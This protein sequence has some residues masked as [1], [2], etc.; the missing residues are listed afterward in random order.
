MKNNKTLILLVLAG[1]GIWYYMKKK[2]TKTTE[3]LPGG[4]GGPGGGPADYV[5][6]DRISPDLSLYTPPNAAND[7]NFTF[8]IN[9]IK[10]RLGN[11]P[12]TI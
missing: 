10:K 6:Q 8:S 1:L 4:K 5:R 7:I 12:N 2:N 3:V 9:G 11:V